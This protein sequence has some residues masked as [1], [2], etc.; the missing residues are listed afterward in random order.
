[1]ANE[2]TYTTGSGSVFF[3]PAGPNTE[4]IWLG[5]H[6]VGDIEESLGEREVQFR[7]RP[8]GS[9]YD[10]ISETQGPPEMVSVTISGCPRRVL[11]ALY[12]AKC[13]GNL[14]VMR[15]CKGR[16]DRLANFERVSIL[17]RAK[18]Q[19]ITEGEPVNHTEDNA[20]MDEF[21]IQAWPPVIRVTDVAAARRASGETLA[22][23][24]IAANQ[25]IECLNG[26]NG[27]NLVPGDRLIA[28]ADGGAG[29]ANVL[30]STD[31]GTTWTATAADPFA[32]GV[33][34]MGVARVV[35]SKTVTRLIAIREGAGA[36]Q[37][38]AAYSDDNGATWTTVNIGGAT[39][40]HGPTTGNAFVVRGP[41]FLIFAGNA[42]YIYKSTDGG[43]SWR[44]VESGGVS[45]NAWTGLDFLD[46]LNGVAVNGT[47]GV[48]AVTR[49]GG[50]SWTAATAV[51]G[52]PALNCVS[53]VSPYS[54]WVG[55]ATGLL[56]YSNDY[57]ITW[58]GRTGWT[59][60]GVGQVRSIDFANDLVGWMLSNNASPVG[61]VLRTIDGGFTWTVITTPTNSGLNDIWAID[62]NHAFACGEANGGTG[63]I[64]EIGL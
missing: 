2:T 62:E 56:F 5:Y 60:S 23:N 52:T 25:D 32:V 55:T 41:T 24:S 11:D 12:T 20:I 30:V 22:I 45:A 7:R 6:D 64:L 37:G 63:V 27:T 1:M 51:T 28:G 31:N 47:A 18:P 38:A 35:I 29:S 16:L 34:I 40:G 8:D 36:T 9:G 53:V 17:Y 58:T 49:D 50:E 59:G 14:F 21:E 39:A 57:G 61:T 48:V 42:G 44:A 46:D 19:S 4:P 54:V 15:R 3:Q 26:C 33:N 13:P 10:A 43:A